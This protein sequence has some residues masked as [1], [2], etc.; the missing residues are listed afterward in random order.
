MKFAVLG[1]VTTFLAAAV[2][3]QAVASNTSSVAPPVAV[4]ASTATMAV[5]TPSTVSACAVQST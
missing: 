3:A 4:A 5:P 1:F 2:Q